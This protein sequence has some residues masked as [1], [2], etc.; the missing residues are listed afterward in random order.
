LFTPDVLLIQPRILWLFDMLLIIRRLCLAATLPDEHDRTATS[1]QQAKIRHL[2]ASPEIA[3]SEY[4]DVLYVYC[5]MIEYKLMLVLR[6][7]YWAGHE[8]IVGLEGF[9]FA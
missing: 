5:G 6:D 8:I 7:S 9:G 3:T 4:R 1:D 2:L